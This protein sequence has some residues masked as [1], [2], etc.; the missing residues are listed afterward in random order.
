MHAFCH[1]LAWLSCFLLV[2]LVRAETPVPAALEPWRGWVLQ[3]QEFRACPLIAGKPG[4]AADDFLCAWPGVLTLAAD[5]DGASILQHWR[6]DAESWIPLPGNEEYW[7]Q[8]VSLDGRPVAVVDHGGP[9]IRLPAGSHEIR[10]RIPW[11]ERPQSLRVPMSTGIVA[12]SVD[13]KA[14]APV[15]RNGDELTL[16]RA[17]S[18]A[19]EADSIELRVYRRLEDG[20]PAQLT[21]VI[22]IYVSGQAREEV[23]GPVLV[24]GF[25]PMELSGEWPA[26]LDADGRLRVRVQ[27]GNDTLTLVA[28]ATAPLATVTAHLP[29][30]PWPKQ[31]IWSYA[32]AP[33]LR[34]TTATSALQV[35][36]RQAQVPSEWYDLP[37]F[38]LADAAVLKIDERT[39]GLAEDDRNRLTL[40]REMWLDFDGSGWFSR[41]RV[42][43]E[44]LQGWRFDAAAPF[45]LERADAIGIRVAGRP[46]EALLVTH[47]ARS[48]LTGVEWRMPAV[49]LAAS[50]RV[51]PA[52]AALPVNGWQDTFDRVTT[53]LHLPD[54]YR[55]LGA[56]G[57]DSTSGSWI[58]AWSLLDVFVAAI[59]VLLAWRGIGLIGAVVAAAYLVLGYQESG[60]PL[61]TLLAVL[62]L[63]LIVRALPQGRLAFGAEWL[64]RATLLLLVLA[65]LP[66][67]A[68]QLRYALYPQLESE[69]VYAVG[70]AGFGMVRHRALK[71]N[72]YDD[73]AEPA[74]A[75]APAAPP[76]PPQVAEESSVTLDRAAQQESEGDQKL[77]PR[78]V[79]G[80]NV[81]N[82]D[83]IDHYSQS[84]VVQTGAGEP[85]WQRGQRYQLAWSG[86]VLPAQNVRLVIAPPWLVRIL[87]VAMVVMLGWLL[88]RLLRPS[89]RLAPSR[90]AVGLVGAFAAGA[91]GSWSPA[92]A[93]AFPPDNLLGE[94]RT[95][96]SEPPKC[97]PSC[98]TIAK[99]EAIARGE[100]IRVA[101]EAHALEPS[102]LPVPF[103]DKTVS[104]RSVIVDGQAQDGLR[105]K[106]GRLWLALPRGVHR[107]ELVF[108]AAADKVS[109]AFP[110][111]PMRVLFD[112]DGWEASGI[113]EGRLLTET[114]TL[115]RS[116]EAGAAPAASGAQQFAPFV[117]VTRSI[118]LGLDWSVYTHVLRMA[119]KEGGFTIAVPLLSGEHVLTPG[120]KVDDG[121]VTAAIAD[122]AMMAVWD[123]KLDKSDTLTLTAPPLGDRAEIWRVLISPTWHADFSG[124][125]AVAMSESEDRK[126][127]RNFEFHPLPGETL[128]LRI[129][130]PQAAQGEARAIDGVSLVHAVGQRAANSTL[131]LTLR[132]SQGGEHV[133]TLPAESE[134]LGVTRN[135]VA[136]NLRAQEGKLSLPI[137]PGPQTFEVRLRDNAPIGFRARTPAIGLGL[138]A[139]NID[140][141]LNLPADRWLLATSGPTT[142]PAVLYW[143]ELAV[144]L[145]VAWALSRTRR[146]P[147]KLW[148]WILLGIGFSTFSWLA[149][150]MVVAWLFALDW[151]A[152]SAALPSAVAFNLAQAG[153]AVLTVAALLCLV[154]AIPQGL[155]GTPDMHV[156]GNQ[157]SA[158]AL[159]WFADRSADALPQAS[160]ISVPLWVYKLAM[161]AWALWLA[162]AVIG[163]LRYGFAAWTRDGYWRRTPRPA[164]DLP[165]ATPPPTPARS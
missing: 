115:V 48:E 74:M 75:P 129:T 80:S 30:A 72:R 97:A 86:P 99:A 29:A 6:I 133:I 130:R 158:Q 125:P 101:V 39:R 145:L 136:L 89:M 128:T 137:A 32:A 132:A 52:S 59:V 67:V 100:E 93:Q 94:L 149:L 160:A 146:T 84:T 109:L 155:L 122:G 33:R 69:G 36:P 16:G 27:P 82:V 68:S 161:L 123:G 120:F 11:A 65:A 5:A 102:A 127:Y 92:Q 44:M 43:G 148:Q 22:E 25:A 142:G 165:A 70:G 10:A 108:V 17:E 147:L 50:L 58:S 151:R 126:D 73:A 45:A 139:A 157:S 60:A 53:T 111:R 131:S 8:Q 83:M 24:D 107:V 57:A 4:N 88:V 91:L 21:T 51:A 20:V 7:P 163:W 38:A 63:V 9:A 134:V 18:S 28:R 150:L 1:R 87:R 71:A 116:H 41:D 23:I 135:G 76:P 154:A 19:P 64:R 46:D 114:L 119:P 77:E 110:A 78:T 144:M 66:F 47:G 55:L 35:D 118:T 156:A 95:H 105:G 81:R 15:Q 121:H 34:V 124:V 96:L 79:S 98:A 90:A 3:G 164:V 106:D 141:G 138:Q 112:G 40:D 26:R 153:L 31:E 61:W 54:G 140:L 2:A 143:S 13:G 117:S 42:R 56:P 162:N 152:R 37:A 62:A 103:D 159:R 12:L 14:V 104:L 113:A 49:D 85:G